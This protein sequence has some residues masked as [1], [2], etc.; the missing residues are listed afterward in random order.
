MGNIQDSSHN[1]IHIIGNAKYALVN[2]YGEMIGVHDDHRSNAHTVDWSGNAWYA[3]DVYVGSTS[4]I[5]KDGGSKKLATEDF[6][7]ENASSDGLV[8]INNT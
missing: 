4:G 3:G 6:V 1:Y 5:N 2:E 8:K 7:L